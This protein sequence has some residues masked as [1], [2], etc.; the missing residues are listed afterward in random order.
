MLQRLGHE[1]VLVDD[2]KKAVAAFS[3]HEFD[4]VLMDLQMPEMDGLDAT[5]HIRKLADVHQPVVIALTAN[6]MQ[7]DR[8]ACLSAGIDDFLSKPVTL[9]E[10]SRKLEEFFP[11]SQ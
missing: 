11:S 4:L 3:D 2:G 8:D 7:S 9:K 5:R 1:P 6:A 10:L